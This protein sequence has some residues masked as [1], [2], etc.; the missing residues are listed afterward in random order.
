MILIRG[1]ASGR[2][3]A[4]TGI[5]LLFFAI[6]GAGSL[7]FGGD[8]L[9]IFRRL[10]GFIAIGLFLVFAVGA[11]L[12][13]WASRAL[14]KMDG[15]LLKKSP[16]AGVLLGVLILTYFVS[17][18]GVSFLRH[19]YFHSSYDLGI[20]DQVVWN[21]AHG[22]L[23]ARSIE[24]TN[25]LGD[26]VRLYLAPLSLVYLAIPSPYVLLTFQSLVLAL[27]A[28]PLYRLTRRK[29]D[30]PA[31]GLV[32]AFCGLA[33]PPLGFLNRYDFHI[34]VVSIPLLIAAFERIDMGDLKNAS[35]L[36]ALTLFCK[37]NLGLTVAGLGLMT[38]LCYKHWRFG[39]TWALTGLAYSSIALLVVIP[40]FRGEPSDTLARYQ[41]LGDTPS[42]M[43][44]GLLSQP[45]FILE[46]TL[47][48]GHILTLLQL[49]APLIFL[50]LLGLPAL[51]PAVPTLIYNFLAEWPSQ[52][53]IYQH[54]M[55]P[56]IP[57]VLIAAVIGLYRLVESPC[58]VKFL[59]SIPTGAL[60]SN[61]PVG[62]SVSVLLAAILASWVYENPITGNA[63]LVWGKAPEMIPMGKTIPVPMIWPNDRA[64]RQGLRHVP[65]GAALLT[66][67][68]YAPH[69]SHRPKIEMISR[70]P[71]SFEAGASPRI[72]L[73][74]EETFSL[75]QAEVVFLNL[76]DLRWWTCA[77][78]FGNLKA[79]AELN[80]GVTFHQ[81]D[82][83]VVQKDKGDRN[84]LSKLL[85][86]WPGCN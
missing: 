5:I 10:M 75:P 57:F 80:F 68:N 41:W 26:H 31:I 7:L 45:V 1:I 60:R 61:K 40:A 4:A 51:L 27:S 66:T 63:S 19:Y 14:E 32:V 16:R 83:I 25:D 81:D 79:A 3:A 17:W 13:E 52:T 33:Y 59:N 77:D 21:T 15:W 22:D 78:Y 39:L 24:V 11:I 69:L 55:A 44:W 46:R 86:Q 74:S 34:E 71:T 48:T 82:V 9:W 84:K 20:M 18:C 42:Q 37:E 43:L 50:P 30:S 38:G 67:A 2:L 76:R 53:V 23:F 6:Y 28:W 47:A 29:L 49:F 58:S 73:Q 54:Y 62:L 56:V 70:A 64:I 65:N 85:L 36:M 72:R 12:G 8:Q 35:L